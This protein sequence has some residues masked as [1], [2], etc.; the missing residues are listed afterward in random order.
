MKIALLNLP[1]DNNYGG[2]LQR[3]ALCKTLDIMGYDATFLNLY[4]ELTPVPYYMA[5][6]K[7]AN[8]FRKKLFGIYTPPLH[9]VLG[10]LYL[11]KIYNKHAIKFIEKNIPCTKP[12]KSIE[13]LKDYC[14]F[15]CYIVG[16]DQVWRKSIA[17]NY[18][19]SM[20]FDFLPD[21]V[22]RIAFSVSMGSDNDELSDKEI[23]YYKELYSKFSAVSVRETSS[24]DLFDKYNWISPLPNFTIDPTLLLKKEDYFGLIGPI[25][26]QPKGDVF[27]YILDKTPEKMT[28]I[29]EYCFDK[30]LTP[31]YITL[32]DIGNGA[33]IENWLLSISVAKFVIT[34]SYH[35]LL[36]AIIFNKPYH[37]FKNKKRGNARFDCILDALS[38]SYDKTDND[39]TMINTKRTELASN[40]LRFLKESL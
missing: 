40:A 10:S 25:N 31:Y 32:Q 13:N 3:Y 26:T 35:G 23:K 6:I 21:D 4:L 15:D 24:L 33:S 5:P 17:H 16:S 12:I 30:N 1:I 2:I 14:N 27:C 37:L 29:K 36:F 7:L 38:L 8:Y 20:F 28:Y 22:K 19:S 34:D 11:Y 18:L 39:W 9:I